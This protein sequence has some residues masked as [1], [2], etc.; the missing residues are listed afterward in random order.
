MYRENKFVCCDIESVQCS[1]CNSFYCFKCHN[2]ISLN[3][4]YYCNDCNYSIQYE[5]ERYWRNLRD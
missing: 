2:I 5:F 3:N 4:K 1:C